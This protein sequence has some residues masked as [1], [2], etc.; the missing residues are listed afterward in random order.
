ML[1]SFD[2]L[3]AERLRSLS[4]PFKDLMGNDFCIKLHAPGAI[5]AKRGNALTI[6]SWELQRV[7]KKPVVVLIDEYDTPIH[8]AIECSYSI[9]VCSSVLLL[10]LLYAISGQQFFC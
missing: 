6:L 1:N 3:V 7:Y 10:Q 8:S 5:Q 2:G 4:Y 9:E